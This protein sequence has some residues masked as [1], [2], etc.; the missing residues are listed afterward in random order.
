MEITQMCQVKIKDNYNAF[1][2]GDRLKK[3]CPKIAT[4]VISGTRCCEKHYNK[5]LKKIN[6]VSP[7]KFGGL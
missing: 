1:Y 5:I 7:H 6:R 4:H 2:F 3:P